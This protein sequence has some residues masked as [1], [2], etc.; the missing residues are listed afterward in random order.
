[1]VIDFILKFNDMEIKMKIDF[2]KFNLSKSLELEIPIIATNEVFYLDKD[3][4]E[5]HDA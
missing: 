5:A 3:M 1:M 2:E 4:H